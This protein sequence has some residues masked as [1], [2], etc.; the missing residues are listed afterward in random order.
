MTKV[1]V[2]DDVPTN[3]TVLTRMLV[4]QGYVVTP[5]MS[6]QQALDIVA[7][8]RPDIILLDVSMPE[9]SGIEVCKRLKGDP[10]LR[11]IPII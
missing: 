10:V 6:G 3:V 9:M 11:L 4:H 8:E 2:V 1:L 5:A 7:V